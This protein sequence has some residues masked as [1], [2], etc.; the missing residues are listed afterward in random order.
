MPCDECISTVFK[1]KLGRCK[2][3][4]WQLLIL[5]LVCWPLWFVYY[6]DTPKVVESVALLLFSCVFTLLLLLHL[7]MW[8]I[9]RV[10]R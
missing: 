4:M 1:R 10:R 5:S 8:A 3:C 9:L 7:L 2:R 6:S